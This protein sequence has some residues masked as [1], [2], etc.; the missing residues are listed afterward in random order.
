[1]GRLTPNLSSD[2]STPERRNLALATPP[3]SPL[4]PG[5]RQIAAVPLYALTS[6]LPSPPPL[7]LPAPLFTAQAHTT[8]WSPTNRSL[9][10]PASRELPG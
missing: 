7:V 10:F 2:R 6:V 3:R 8:S 1:M 4:L 9:E 5:D